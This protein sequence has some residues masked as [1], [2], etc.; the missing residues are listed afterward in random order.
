M[1]MQIAKIQNYGINFCA[2]NEPDKKVNKKVSQTAG[3]KPAGD[4]NPISKLGERETLLKATV[5]T[6]LGV[7]ARA[8]WYL[9]S[10]GFA[11][12][13]IFNASEKLVDKNKKGLTG[14][15]RSIAHL[16]AFAALII[17]FIAAVAVGYTV[18]KTPNVMYDGKVNAF[19][20]GKDMDVYVK[21]NKVEKHLYD[22]MNDK[23]KGATTEEKEKLKQQYLKLK[24]AKNQTPDFV[25]KA[26]MPPAQ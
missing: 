22:Q 26:E 4:E 13:D 14:A 2:D 18:Y 16:G 12:D 23:A 8:L 24:A 6:G 21:S 1:P 19:K 17:G 25:D 10:E 7:G 5:I 11:W 15:K 3:K 9:T 20:K